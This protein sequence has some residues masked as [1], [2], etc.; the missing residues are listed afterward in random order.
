MFEGTL[1]A[2][3]IPML[4]DRDA[5]PVAG[6]PPTLAGMTS[7]DSSGTPQFSRA[8]GLLPPPPSWDAYA[9]TP[10]PP[11]ERRGGADIFIGG[12]ADDLLPHGVMRDYAEAYARQTGRPTRYFPNARIGG[13]VDAIQQG[14]ANGGPVN[15]VGHSWGGPDAYNAVARANAAGL[16]VDNL[17]TLD[18]VSGPSRAVEGVA[19]A[20]T[21]MNVYGHPVQPDFTDQIASFPWLAHKPSDLPVPLADEPIN[22][23]LHH[24]DA[25][26]M[27][28]QSGA[29]ELLDRSRRFDVPRVGAGPQS[30]WSPAA[31]ALH[32]NLP[33][34]EWMRQRQA[35]LRAQR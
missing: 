29:R 21:W 12:G 27:M 14:D 25:E 2:L 30:G 18:P 16:P 11:R 6:S 4:R 34:M 31:Q 15:V 17:I 24:G 3:G 13:V 33:M 1:R 9:Q 5:E 8:P 20:G 22:V 23:R 7:Q 26:G 28:Q 19:H 10:P 32:D 35:E